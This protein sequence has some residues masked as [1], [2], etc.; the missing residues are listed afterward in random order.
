MPKG[1]NEQVAESTFGSRSNFKAWLLPPYLLS[2][3][4]HGSYSEL[5]YSVLSFLTVSS[6]RTNVVSLLSGKI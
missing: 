5:Y 2:L 1:I 3:Q 6:K 4:S